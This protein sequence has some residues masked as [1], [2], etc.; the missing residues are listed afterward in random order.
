MCACYILNTAA[1]TAADTQL[2][3]VSPAHSIFCTETVWCFHVGSGRSRPGQLWP[4]W[5]HRHLGRQPGRW[6]HGWLMMTSDGRNSTECDQ[7]TY[8]ISLTQY[9][10]GVF[11]TRVIWGRGQLELSFY[12]IWFNRFWE[13]LFIANQVLY[14]CNRQYVN[15]W[16][17]QEGKSTDDHIYT[18]FRADWGPFLNGVCLECCRSTLHVNA[19]VLLDILPLELSTGMGPSAL[20]R[21]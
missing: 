13:N 14:T 17:F 12:S 7:R 19:C 9:K 8:S 21:V 2:H 10:G 4:G 5:R 18:S 3:S 16:P 6:L 11:Y 20:S 15:T 1:Q